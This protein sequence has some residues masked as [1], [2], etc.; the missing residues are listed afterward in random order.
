[1]TT[2]TPLSL[3]FCA[4]PKAT[5]ICVTST[6]QTMEARASQLPSASH[7]KPWRDRVC[8]GS[9]RSTTSTK[10]P[11]SDP[12]Q[13]EADLQEWVCPQPSTSRLAPPTSAISWDENSAQASCSYLQDRKP[14]TE[15]QQHRWINGIRPS[16]SLPTRQRLGTCSLESSP[17]AP[18][19]MIR[20]WVALSQSAETTAR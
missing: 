9:S 20:V 11:H 7:C 19:D 18:F 2:A 17:D 3:P 13:L 6:S 1:M 5:A 10:L 12:E 4:R 14:R 8:L 15:P 16:L